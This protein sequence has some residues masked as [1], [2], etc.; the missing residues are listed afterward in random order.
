MARLAL[1]SSQRLEKYIPHVFFAAWIIGSAAF[2][3]ANKESAPFSREATARYVGAGVG[4]GFLLAGLV[5]SVLTAVHAVAW[6]L[7]SIRHTP[8][9]DECGRHTDDA[10]MVPGAG[11]NE[12]RLRLLYL[13]LL[14]AAVAAL[15][16]DCRVSQWCVAARYPHPLGE[17][18]DVIVAFG[19][20]I[21]TLMIILAVYCLDPP[22]R[23]AIWWLAGCAWLSGM[24]A[25]GGK[26]LVARIRPYAFDFSGDVWATFGQLTPATGAYQSW[27]SGHTATALGLALG[28]MMVYPRGRSLF[29][30]VAM[31]VACQRIACGAH[32]LS[33][34]LSGAAISCLTVAC[35]LRMGQW[36]KEAR[37]KA[38][39]RK[40]NGDVH[41]TTSVCGDQPG[42]EP[43]VTA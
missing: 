9:A 33:D 41:L 38:Q 8:C 28:L 14:L 34:V 26:L 1:P 37:A 32:Y 25:N 3:T 31:L 16:I 23:R 10:S 27:P 42:G 15:G 19:N 2:F 24:A 29:L 12:R 21:M 20:G 35:C 39:R 6:R 40:E 13:V 18:L 22:R 5:V 4:A 11:Y 43:G 7:K 17:F 36:W 30:L